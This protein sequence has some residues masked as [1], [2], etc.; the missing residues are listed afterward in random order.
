MLAALKNLSSAIRR[1]IRSPLTS[2]NC[3]HG[4]KKM[5]LEWVSK[6]FLQR[7]RWEAFAAL[8]SLLHYLILPLV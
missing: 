8:Q 1:D 2:L 5:P 6:W 3:M 7:A 4:A